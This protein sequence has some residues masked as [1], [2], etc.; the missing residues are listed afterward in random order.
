MGVEC[1]FSSVPKEGRDGG[2]R[3]NEE[4]EIEFVTT[5]CGAR[6]R[7]RGEEEG[8]CPES[9]CKFRKRSLSVVSLHRLL[10]AAAA[11]QMWADV[12]E[13]ASAV[14]AAHDSRGRRTPVKDF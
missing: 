11:L 13:A 8:A 1:R 7:R 10:A 6:R 9:N 12:L 3:L 2:R 5:K 14:C 4:I